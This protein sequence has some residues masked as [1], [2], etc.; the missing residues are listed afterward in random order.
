MS[1]HVGRALWTRDSCRDQV[2]AGQHPII[3]IGHELGGGSDRFWTGKCSS[4]LVA[5]APLENRHGSGG[6]FIVIDDEYPA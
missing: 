4:G 1:G 5:P 6:I 3:A 2:A